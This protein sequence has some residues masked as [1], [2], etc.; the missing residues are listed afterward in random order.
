M[1]KLTL[2]PIPAFEDNYIWCLSDPDTQNTLV[3][4]PGI[5]VDNYLKDAGLNLVGI[6]L[7]HHHADHTGGVSAMLRKHKVPVFG[8]S[9]INWVTH[10]LQDQMIANLAG[11]HAQ[12]LAT[13][14][15]TQEHIVYYFDNI[16]ALLSGDTLFASGCGRVFDNTYKELFSSLTALKLLPAA[17]HVYCSHEYTQDNLA[18]AMEV[19][20]NYIGM[21]AYS[22][23]IAALRKEGKP[24]LPTLLADEW[25][26]NPFLRCHIPAVSLAASRYAGQT[27]ST[28]LEVFTALRKWKNEF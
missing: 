10:P 9:G 18:F 3:F 5:P 7:T 13:P 28:E 16:P 19:E 26:F 1:N 11:F 4:D 22:T 24:S 15:H 2:T 20:P 14:G 6:C 12:I 23:K 27:L 8:P 17:T 25:Q 21:I